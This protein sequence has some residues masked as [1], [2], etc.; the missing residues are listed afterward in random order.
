MRKVTTLDR[1]LEAIKDKRRAMSLRELVEHTG[2]SALAVQ[3]ALSRLL[4]TKRLFKVGQVVEPT[5]RR[6]VGIY[7]TKRPK[8]KPPAT[9]ATESELVTAGVLSR[10]A[11]LGGPFGIL[12]AQLEA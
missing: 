5:C 7:S 4:A 12:V 3:R 9:M 1:V 8:A 6:P 2:L 10:A 11:Q